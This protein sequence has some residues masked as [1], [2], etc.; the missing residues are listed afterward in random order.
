MTILTRAAKGS[1]LSHVEMDTNW[2]DLRD[3]P[4]GKVFPK[5]QNVGIKIDTA[6]PDYG[7]ADLPGVIHTDPAGLNNPTMNNYI[8]GIYE[9]QFSENDE[10]M[11]RFHLPHDYAMGTDLFIHAHWS[12][13]SA[14]VT[15]G[16]CTFAFET[17]CAKG[18]DQAAFM[19]TKTVSIIQNASTVQYQHMIAETSLT[20]SGGSVTQF[21]TADNEPDAMFICRFYLDSNDMTVSGGGIPEPFVHMFDLHYQTTGIATKQKSPNF[22]T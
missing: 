12:H 8:G 20:V 14:L 7:W 15:G 13:N 5:T 4:N 16:S 21:D 9:P 11:V 19:P 3:I 6:S 18:H 1:A 2:T 10:S 17:T 22:W